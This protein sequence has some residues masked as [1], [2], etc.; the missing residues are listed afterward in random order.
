[1]SACTSDP[2]SPSAKWKSC[3]SP[4][5]AA[6]VFTVAL[7]M[8]FD[9]WA[10]RRSGNASA[11]RPAERMSSATASASASVVPRYGPIHVAVSSTYWT[12]SSA[13]RVPLMNVTAERIGQLPRTAT[14]SSAPRPFCTVMSV[15]PAKRPASSSDRRSR[16]PPLH[17]TTTRSA[18]P[19]SSG[20][21]DA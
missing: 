13:W 18:G 8:S 9:H 15:A 10:G 19:S 1:M 3:G 17:A 16:S 14:T 5:S 7:K 11:F 6:T 20:S 4:V 21:V 12:W 2:S